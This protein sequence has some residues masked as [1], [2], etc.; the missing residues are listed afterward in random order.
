MKRPEVLIVMTG[1]GTEVGKTWVG[2][3]LLAH[4]RSNGHVVAAR[5]PAQSFDPADQHPRDSEVLAAATGELPQNVCLPERN[6]ELAVAPPM[7]ADSL[8]RP[9]IH[10][11]D[12]VAEMMIPSEVSLCLVEGAGGV[13]SPLAHDGD[14]LGLISLLRPDV[15]VLVADP[16]LGTINAVRLSADALAGQRLVVFLNRFDESNELHQ[17]N[18]G[19]L[20]DTAALSVVTTVSDLFAV[21]MK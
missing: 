16:G 21:C 17:W 4:A 1:T 12:L 15:V 8:S 11:A 10:L 6:Y 13:R 2:A 9:R 3:E 20:S 7:A 14:T 5:K 18:R 19:I